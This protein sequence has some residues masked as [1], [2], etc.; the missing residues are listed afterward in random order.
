MRAFVLWIALGA[1]ACCACS[2]GGASPT[3]TGTATAGSAAGDAASSADVAGS[4]AG[5]DGAVGTATDADAGAGRPAQAS[6]IGIKAPPQFAIY[7]DQCDFLAMC[8]AAGKCYCGKGCTTDKQ[9]CSAALCGGVDTTCWCGETCQAQKKIQ[10]P[11][12]ICDKLDIKDCQPQDGCVFNNAPPPATCACT[13][14]PDHEADCWCGSKCSKDIPGYLACSEAKCAGKNPNGCVAVPG[15][16]FKS[17]YC[18]T[19]GLLGP[20]PTCFYGEC[21]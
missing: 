15:V 14:M 8:P 21:P 9:K 18:S 3:L 16:K 12:F 7:N 5:S 10:C 19:C 6:C 4:G 2:G 11:Q 1:A 20:T 13:K 17:C